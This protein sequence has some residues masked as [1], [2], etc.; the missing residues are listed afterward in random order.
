MP[1]NHLVF[2]Y[3]TLKQGFSNHYYLSGSKF[4]GTGR[5]KEKYAMYVSGIPFVIM[6]EP[7]S[8]IQGELYQVDDITLA[9]LDSLEGH[10][11]WYRREKVD[12]CLYDDCS[13]DNVRQAWIYFCDDRSG[14]LIPSG[15]FVDR[16][17]SKA[18]PV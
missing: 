18:Y 15:I 3:G 14:T 4:L 16:R 1:E 9:K 8:P 10:P 5:T 6:S 2:V 11:G 13:Q 12:V 7:I 17:H